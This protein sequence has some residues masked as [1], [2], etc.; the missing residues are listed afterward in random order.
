MI[1]LSYYYFSLE[2]LPRPNSKG[3]AAAAVAAE[4]T[5]PLL[6]ATT[7]HLRFLSL[8]RSPWISFP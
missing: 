8:A 5:L 1:Y 4:A 2:I 6:L 7:T 3:L